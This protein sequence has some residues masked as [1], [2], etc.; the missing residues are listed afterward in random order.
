MRLLFIAIV[1]LVAFECINGYR[2]P[3]RKMFPTRK[4]TILTVDDDPGEPLFLTPYLE[5]GKIEEARQ[6]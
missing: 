4:P 6:L 5:Q 2:G 1:C 3:F